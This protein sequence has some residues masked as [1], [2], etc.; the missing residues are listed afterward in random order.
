MLPFVEDLYLIAFT[1]HFFQLLTTTG[2]EFPKTLYWPSTWHAGM[3]LS[4]T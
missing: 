1:L 4:H 3:V 2:Q